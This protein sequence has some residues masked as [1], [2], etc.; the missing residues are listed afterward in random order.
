MASRTV[1]GEERRE[2]FDVANFA[3]HLILGT[4]IDWPPAATRTSKVVAIPDGEIDIDVFLAF[5]WLEA[6]AAASVP[7]FEFFAM[8]P[9]SG[10]HGDPAYDEL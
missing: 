5:R 8:L 10:L 4:R 7:F 9:K 6:I 1:F 3:T 2:Y